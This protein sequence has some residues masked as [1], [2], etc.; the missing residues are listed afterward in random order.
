[1]QTIK[2][3]LQGAGGL[4]SAD[5]V[6]VLT[7]PDSNSFPSIEKVGAMIEEMRPDWDDLKK[8][9][10]SYPPPPECQA[11]ADQYDGALQSIMDTIDQVRNIVDNVSLNS[12]SEIKGSAD[13]TR[14]VGRNHRRSI[15]GNFEK[16]D[17]LVQDVCDLYETRKW[18]KI[19]A[20]GGSSGL[21]GF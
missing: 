12:A 13:E 19:D 21:L 10:D 16:A 20:H 17:D 4:T 2:S 8:D 5:D 14:K 7:D 11:I 3:S 6:N 15:D 9:F 18:F 1:M